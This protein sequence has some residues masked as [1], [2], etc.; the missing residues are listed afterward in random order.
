MLTYQVLPWNII[1][2]QL[3]E[4]ECG[5]VRISR[6]VRSRQGTDWWFALQSDMT[7][8]GA[9]SQE[10]LVSSQWPTARAHLNPWTLSWRFRSPSELSISF[11]LWERRA[12][13]KSLAP[14]QRAFYRLAPR[15]LPSR[16]KFAQTRN[17]GKGAN[18]QGPLLV[19][20][21]SFPTLWPKEADWGP[22]IG[23]Q[24]LGPSTRGDN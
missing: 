24:S 20:L 5:L 7:K 2:H 15:Q 18:V 23:I 8:P 16:V 4:I 12:I 17:A 6:F 1:Q 9:Y 3:Y 14:S 22:V 13:T 21:R 11:S 10:S 19:M